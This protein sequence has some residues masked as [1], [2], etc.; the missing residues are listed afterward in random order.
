MS[1]RA[2][3]LLGLSPLAAAQ[4]PAALDACDVVWS[5]PSRDASGSMPI[6]NGEVALMGVYGNLSVGALVFCGRH[7]LPVQHWNARLVRLVFWSLNIGLALMVAL[8]TMPAGF[9][10]L[11][12][13]L[14]RGLWF[15]RSQEWIG[16]TTFQ[17]LTWLRLVGGATFVL[18]GVVPLAWFCIARA[19][20]LRPDAVAVAADGE[21][22]ARPRPVRVNPVDLH[23]A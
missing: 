16:G 3:A 10:H 14:E 19:G 7:L 20:A 8:D 2:F 22:D 17:T 21:S 9:A 11:D 15:A 13:V 18:G 6:G 4:T 1:A 23:P 12:T 5:S